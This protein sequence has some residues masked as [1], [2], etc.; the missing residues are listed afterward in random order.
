M[1]PSVNV[2]IILDKLTSAAFFMTFGATLLSTVLI[3]YQIYSVTR[4]DPRKGTTRPYTDI[5][6]VLVQSAAAYSLVAL[7]NALTD[8]IPAND[9]NATALFCA[10]SYSGAPLL[11]IAVRDPTLLITTDYPSC[12]T[13]RHFGVLGHGANGHSRPRRAEGV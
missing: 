6:E 4:R 1:D 10:E 8:I 11:I 13:L 9:T 7:L 12:A 5:A 2:Q 3:A